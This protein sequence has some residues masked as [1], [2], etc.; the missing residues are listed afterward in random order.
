MENELMEDEKAGP[1]TSSQCDD[2][3]KA[4]TNPSCG[5]QPATCTRGKSVRAAV[6]SA[7]ALAKR[8]YDAVDIARSPVEAVQTLNAPHPVLPTLA[9]EK[10][11]LPCTD[12]QNSLPSGPRVRVRPPP[13]GT[14]SNRSAASSET[15]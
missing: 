14:A 9:Q 11:T 10:T 1:G 8:P 7:D 4:P 12:T 5:K 6:P 15:M 13:S 3:A 2:S